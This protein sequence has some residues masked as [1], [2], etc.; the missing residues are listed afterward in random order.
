MGIKD[1]PLSTKPSSST[2]V[3]LP[4]TLETIL[5]TSK[6]P[7]TVDPQSGSILKIL[8][9]NG[10][11]QKIQDGY[12]SGRT[13]T[14]LHAAPSPDFTLVETWDENGTPRK[15]YQFFKIVSDVPSPKIPVPAPIKAEEAGEV[16][17]Q[18]KE[19]QAPVAAP[20]PSSEIPATKGDPSRA[21]EVAWKIKRGGAGMTPDDWDYRNKNWA[22]IEKFLMEKPAE[23][24]AEVPVETEKP[25]PAAPTTQHYES[26]SW[27]MDKLGVSKAAAPVIE[28]KPAEPASTAS[29]YD[30]LKARFAQGA[31]SAQKAPEVP[32][33]NPAERKNAFL[34]SVFDGAKNEWGLA[35]TIP[36]RAFVYPTE[37]AWGTDATGA[38]VN[39]SLEDYPPHARTLRAKIS[40]SIEDVAMKGVNIETATVDQ[41]LTAIFEKGLM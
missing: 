30:L 18:P 38:P 6:G 40:Q 24:G 2:A 12:K 4:P 3:P 7:V 29:S 39:R 14:I 35:K 16:I 8:S 25:K 17:L 34:D 28:T 36:A 15:N 19:I 21:E 26:K 33:A 13:Y 23:K 9:E 31:P 27:L 1:I 11:Q 32:A 22:E 37:Y 20:K 5:Q 41:A 10:F